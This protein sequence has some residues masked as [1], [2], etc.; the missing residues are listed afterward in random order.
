M[1][2]EVV[3]LAFDPVLRLARIRL[4]YPRVIPPHMRPGYYNAEQTPPAVPVGPVAPANPIIP[5]DT[6]Q[7]RQDDVDAQTLADEEFAMRLQCEEWGE[8]MEIGHSSNAVASSSTAGNQLSW[9]ELVDWEP[10]GHG[11]VSTWGAPTSRQLSTGIRT[12]AVAQPPGMH[13]S[14]SPSSYPYA[15]TACLPSRGQGSP[16]SPPSERSSNNRATR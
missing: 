3:D 11:E 9:E 5:L 15:D 8:P 2:R 4:L 7:P 6:V 14:K 16:T 13:S 1:P 12:E 10:G